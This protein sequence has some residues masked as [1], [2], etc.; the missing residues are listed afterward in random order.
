MITKRI[1]LVVGARPNFVKAAP[2]AQ[3]VGARGRMQASL[4]HTGQHFDDNM[5]AV[6]FTELGMPQPDRYLG[7][8][9][10]SP[11]E[12][13]GRTI[14]ALE[15]DFAQEKP[16]AVVVF[17][18]VNSTLAASV[19]AN[20]LGI[21]L[22]HVEA[23]LRSF[24]RGMPEEHNRVVTDMLADLLL[25][26][27]PDADENLLREGVLQE[28]I[29]R[30]GNIMVDSLLRFKDK[31]AE[32]RAWADFGL[33]AGAYGLVT[34]HRN[35]N[36][37]DPDSLAELARALVALQQEI[38]LLFPVHPRTAEHLQV[39][40]LS[41]KLSEAGVRV[42]EPLGY[43]EF[44]SLMSQ[45][46]FVLTDSGGIQEES[47]VLG[48]PCLTAREHTERPITITMG[49]N[50]LVGTSVEGI[51]AGFRTIQ[52]TAAEPVRPELW[53]GHTAERVEEALATAL[54]LG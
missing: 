52:D 1:S 33:E 10:G 37:D 13:I 40:G 35:F 16:D 6:F 15:E 3:A 2:L 47:T 51:L 7:I 36:V 17:G 8:R 27:S 21:F 49:T 4:V 5:S 45:A 11:A 43:L 18:D 14:L 9:G 53:D 41:D 34:L 50:R 42:L 26:P 22:A 25:T 46:K 19:A 24:D 32:A 29:V 44:L 31:A 39:H 28:R 54:G 48:V 30:V 12:Q 23:G 20:K 38:P